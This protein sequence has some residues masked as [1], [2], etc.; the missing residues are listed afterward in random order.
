MQLISKSHFKIALYFSPGGNCCSVLRQKSQVL[1]CASLA[2]IAS[3]LHSPNALLFCGPEFEENKDDKDTS[4]H[5]PQK[6]GQMRLWC[7]VNL[8]WKLLLPV[9]YSLECVWG[10]QVSH[11]VHAHVR[12]QLCGVHSLL[13]PFYEAQVLNS[14]QVELLC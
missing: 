3:C 7:I 1:H 12:S 8:C 5:L 13:P 4:V 10:A 2:S 6:S 14:G 9:F 11:S